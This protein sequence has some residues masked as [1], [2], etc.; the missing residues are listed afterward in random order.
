MT[1]PAYFM[2]QAQH[3]GRQAL[4]AACPTCVC[5]LLGRDDLLQR[6]IRATDIDP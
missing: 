3:A 1:C 4:P 6:V 2:Q 5:A